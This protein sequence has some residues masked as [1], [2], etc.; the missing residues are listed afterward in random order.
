MLETVAATLAPFIEREK[1]QVSPPL[2]ASFI[3]NRN[4]IRRL[5]AA[6]CEP[7]DWTGQA[8]R[9]PRDAVVPILIGFLRQYAAASRSS[10]D[11]Q[12]DVRLAFKRLNDD[13]H[14]SS[15]VESAVPI[16]LDRHNFA[17]D[18]CSP[19]RNET[20]WSAAGAADAKR[21]RGATGYRLPK[22]WAN[23]GAFSLLHRGLN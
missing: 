19:G 3:K 10:A 23:A 6:E 13:A 1:P 21:P 17:T 9:Q 11:A 12:V 14:I 4:G 20:T 5:R 16:C 18:R 8:R 22:S 7:S 15:R 2:A